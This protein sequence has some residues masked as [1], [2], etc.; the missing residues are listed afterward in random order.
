MPRHYSS[1]LLLG[2]IIA[3]Y[4]AVTLL[5]SLTLHYTFKTGGQDIGNYTQILTRLL[6]GEGLTATL[7]PPGKLQHWLA[8]HFSPILYLVAL[9]F[10]LWPH[11]V[12]LNALNVLALAAAA[13]PLY[14]AIRHITHHESLSLV[15]AA[16]YLFNPFVF[17][18]AIAGFH[19]SCLAPV[20]IA[21]AYLAL[22]HKKRRWFM[23][24]CVL[25][26]T[27]KEHY[28][29]ALVG[30]GVLW[31]WHHRDYRF[32]AMIAF[33]GIIALALILKVIMPSLSPLEEHFM[34]ASSEG[35]FSWLQDPFS[36]P[37]QLIR[38]SGDGLMYVMM[39]AMGMLLLPLFS[40]LWLLPGIADLAAN[41]VSM[42]AMMRSPYM[43]HGAAL[44]VVFCVAAAVT[45]RRMLTKNSRLFPRDLII[46][47]AV[48]TA[49]LQYYFSAL[50]LRE[51]NFW[52]FSGTQITLSDTDAKAMAD[53]RSM[54]PRSDAVAAQSN[55]AAH[56]GDWPEIYAFPDMY[57]QDKVSWIIL[58]LAYIPRAITACEQYINE[59]EALLSD[60]AWNVAYWQNPWLLLHR[61]ATLRREQNDLSLAN[62]FAVMAAEC[63]KYGDTLD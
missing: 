24:A 30:L 36:Y 2:T 50:P 17:N 29:L 3:A 45:M 60:R 57:R 34:L 35:R 23:A 13:W 46:V 20:I 14:L 1:A 61:G 16:A 51:N 37:L 6:D 15:M 28:G 55:V 21:G 26:L 44:I 53:I 5:Y 10:A 18:A 41:V 19:E 54:V 27:V 52:G 63:E 31:G 49:S 42:K 40:V 43:Y 8:I 32:G 58:R 38:S 62:A 33:V 56:F 12:F 59:V 9:V 22:L 4:I 11:D 25:L 39:L 7:A 48:L 47:V